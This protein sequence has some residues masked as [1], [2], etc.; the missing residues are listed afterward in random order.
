MAM[1]SV[2]SS[3]KSPLALYFNNLTPFKLLRPRTSGVLVIL[4]P[5]H[6]NLGSHVQK[7]VKELVKAPATNPPAKDLEVYT[8]NIGQIPPALASWITG[9]INSGSFCRIDPD[10]E[11]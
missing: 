4:I 1:K 8:V 3:G 10:M 2:Q 5:V 6:V 9:A 7:V 11:T